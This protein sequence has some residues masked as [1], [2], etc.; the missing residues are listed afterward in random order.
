MRRSRIDIVIEILE[1]AKHGVNKTTIVY[2]S[3]LNFTLADKYLELLE[4]QGLLENRSEKFIT[5]DKGKD[6][7]SKAKDLTLQLEEPLQKQKEMYPKLEVPQQKV[8]ELSSHQELSMQKT[9]QTRLYL[10][11]PIPVL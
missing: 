10:E 11:V 4:K 9:K 5:S 6:F 1:V 8:N 3:N 2:R 7:L